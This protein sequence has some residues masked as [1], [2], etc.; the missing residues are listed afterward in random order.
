MLRSIGVSAGQRIG[1]FVIQAYFVIAMIT[2][3]LPASLATLASMLTYVVGPVPSIYGGRLAERY[4]ACL[5][6]L[7]GYGLFV[8]LAAPTF[9]TIANS[10]IVVAGLVA[11]AFTIINNIASATMPVA[12]VLSFRSEDHSSAPP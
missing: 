1:L 6:L 10:S 9:T 5:P 2:A 11:V 8:V 4:R 7:I 12:A 3:G